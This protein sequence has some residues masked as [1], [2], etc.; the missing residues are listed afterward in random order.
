M[1]AGQ[2]LSALK[3]VICGRLTGARRH[4]PSVAP[5]DFAELGQEELAISR[6]I[7]T[8]SWLTGRSFE[9]CPLLSPQGVRVGRVDTDRRHS[10][11]RGGAELGGFCDNMLT[12]AGIVPYFYIVLVLLQLISPM[13]CSSCKM[14]FRATY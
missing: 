6:L 2:L 12:F 3:M 5:T 14:R 13:I 9:R 11:S 1:F 8:E 7:G 4:S 10:T